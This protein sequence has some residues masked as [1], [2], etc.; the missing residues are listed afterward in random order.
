MGPGSAVGEKEKTKI[1]K[2][3]AR[4]ES[5]VPPFPLPPLITFSPTPITLFFFPPYSE[6]GPRL[7]TDVMQL[8]L[9]PKRTTAQAVETSVTVNN[10]SPIQEYVHPNDHT[11]PT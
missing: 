6:P 8:S 4:E 5:T 9:T 3:S 1:G 7:S 10:N 2:I 11:Q